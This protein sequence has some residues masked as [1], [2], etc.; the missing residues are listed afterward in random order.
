MLWGDNHPANI[1]VVETYDVP[2]TSLGVEK[3]QPLDE[4][5]ISSD[6]QGWFWLSVKIFCQLIIFCT[7]LF[8]LVFRL[9]WVKDF[10]PNIFL[11]AILPLVQRYVTTGFYEHFCLRLSLSLSFSSSFLPAPLWS[12][13]RIF[14]FIILRSVSQLL[15][16]QKFLPLGYQWASIYFEVMTFSLASLPF[17]SRPYPLPPRGFRGGF[18]GGWFIS[19][20]LCPPCS[21]FLRIPLL[22]KV[23]RLLAFL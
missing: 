8:D 21:W 17:L 2:Y 11:F 5:H 22:S 1:I 23:K 16:H 4:I 12:G 15:R 20:N 13:H 19:K 18:E 6:V 10:P 14:A 7:L 3:N 9:L